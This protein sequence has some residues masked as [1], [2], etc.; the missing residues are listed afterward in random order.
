MCLKVFET[1]EKCHLKSTSRTIITFGMHLIDIFS[2][3]VEIAYKALTVLL[4]TSV[5]TILKQH[6]RPWL[7]SV[8][9]DLMAN[10][11]SCSLLFWGSY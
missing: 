5:A 8:T 10:F 2:F 7:F 4:I 3:T 9:Q 11:L 6:E 1:L